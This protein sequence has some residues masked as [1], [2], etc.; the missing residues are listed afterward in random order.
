MLSKILHK[1]EP[2]FAGQEPKVYIKS[3]WEVI[4]DRKYFSNLKKDSLQFILQIDYDNR[5]D[6]SILTE[7]AANKNEDA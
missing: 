1:I 6:N 5:Y 2:L 7:K 3:C 4:F